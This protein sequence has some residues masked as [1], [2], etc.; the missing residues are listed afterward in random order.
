MTEKAASLLVMAIVGG[1]VIPPL[2]GLFVDIFL[3]W[4]GNETRALQYAF[5]V[6]IC[7]Y[8]YILWYG[9]IGS[10][11]RGVGNPCSDTGHG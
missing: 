6:S 8:A 7:C 5:F 10:R 3:G 11:L 2:Q 4:T 9:W 1:A